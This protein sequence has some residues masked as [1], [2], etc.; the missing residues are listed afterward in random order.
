MQQLQIIEF[1]VS[2]ESIQQAAYIYNIMFF[3]IYCSTYTRK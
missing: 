1:E 2:S 3:I